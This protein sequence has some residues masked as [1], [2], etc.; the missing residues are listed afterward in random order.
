MNRI[1]GNV[2]IVDSAMG[3]SLLLTS[4]NQ[5]VD[6]NYYSVGAIYV[7]PSS[8]GAFSMRLSEA[9]TQDVVVVVD[10]N[11]MAINFSV[12]QRFNALKI[13]LIANATG[14]IYLV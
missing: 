1:V 10:S 5:P 4:A 2:V 9:N 8:G 3:N 14:F 7:I 12:A 6:L 13:P 11:N